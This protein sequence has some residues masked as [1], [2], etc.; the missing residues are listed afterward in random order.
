MLN[1]V[2]QR[3][4]HHGV[5]HVLL[6]GVILADSHQDRPCVVDSGICV[7]PLLICWRDDLRFGLW[8][9]N[10]EEGVVGKV[11]VKDLAVVNQGRTPTILMNTASSL[12]P[13]Q[14]N[15]AAIGWIP[16]WSKWRGEITNRRLTLCSGMVQV[17]I[18]PSLQ[19][20]IH[21]E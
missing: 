17:E 11:G 6:V 16:L 13:S 9:G 12:F 21:K 8:A 4:G 18:P 2:L 20:Q 19:H 15:A 1:L 14:Y 10:P 7:S 5:H 3:Q